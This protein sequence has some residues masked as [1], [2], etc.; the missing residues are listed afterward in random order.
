MQNT[1]DEIIPVYFS[2]NLSEQLPLPKGLI[3]FFS[4][5]LS[6]TFIKVKRPLQCSGS[7]GGSAN[8]VTASLA[9]AKEQA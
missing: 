3:V 1:G 6:T 5:V 9:S 8:A 4:W 2:S 7:E